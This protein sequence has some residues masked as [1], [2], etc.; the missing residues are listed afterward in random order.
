[1]KPCSPRKAAVLNVPTPQLIAS[2]PNGK[3]CK[4]PVTLITSLESTVE[5]NPDDLQN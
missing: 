4:K 1:M 2:D 5:L 3:E